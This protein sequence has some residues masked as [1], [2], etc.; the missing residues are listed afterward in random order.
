M[1][2]TKRELRNNITLRYI[3]ALVYRFGLGIVPLATTV[4][5]FI[6]KV[7]DSKIL[8]GIFIALA[9][10]AIHIPQVIMGKRVREDENV[11]KSYIFYLILTVI[12]YFLLGICIWYVND[13]TTMV[14]LFYILYMI[15][16]FLRGICIMHNVTLTGDM[17]PRGMLGKYYGYMNMFGNIGDVVGAVAIAYFIINPF[18]FPKRYAFLF[19]IMTLCSVLSLAIIMKVKFVVN[20][21]QSEHQHISYKEY[22]NQMK[23]IFT[24]DKE[25]L[26]FNISK[27]FANFGTAIYAFL[28]IIAKDKIGISLGEIVIINIIMFAGEALFSI[29]W[30]YINTYYE[31][32]YSYV[33]CRVIY[34]VNLLLLLF[35][36]NKTIVYIVYFLY[37]IAISGINATQE[38]A[39][40]D[41]GGK[42]KTMYLA[43]FEMVVV[44]S[45]VASMILMSVLLEFLGYTNSII[46]SAVLILLAVIISVWPVKEKGEI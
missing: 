42:N 22:F 11:D 33:I 46:I 14:I 21:E 40:I 12:S 8:L 13:Y 20:R 41:M 27:I 29:I 6:S 24:H 26:K 32:E 45:L 5:F 7:I 38:K 28:I 44:P 43:I 15:N 25:F 2:L 10:A 19:F 34:V 18:P 17:V 3:D 37:G 9:T 23:K 36:L 35:F 31:W 39:I 16:Q 30:G 1:E 4:S